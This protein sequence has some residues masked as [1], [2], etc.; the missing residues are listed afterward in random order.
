MTKIIITEEQLASLMNE[1]AS[2]KIYH[3]TSI[4]NALKIAEEDTIYLQSSL[5]SQSD[6]SYSSRKLFYLSTTR[7][8]FQAFGYSGGFSDNSVRIELDG[9]KLNE[10]LSAKPYN[11]WGETMGKWHYMKDDGF[12]LTRNKQ[13]H[14]NDE[15]EDRL[16]SSIPSIQGAHNFIKRIDVII[17]DTSDKNYSNYIQ[18]KNL[19]S[20]KFSQRIFIYDN[21]KDFNYQ[22]ENT[23]NNVLFDDMDN[24]NHAI[25]RRHRETYLDNDSINVVLAAILSGESGNIKEDSA[26]LLKKYGLTSYIYKG[27][28]KSPNK[29]LSFPYTNYQELAHSLSYTLSNLSVQPSS[30]KS[31]LLEMITDYFKRRHL[32]TMGDFIKYKE[33]NTSSSNNAQNIN[34]LIDMGIID[35]DKEI[36]ALL[37]RQT[38]TYKEIVVTDPYQVKVKDI[39]PDTENMAYFFINST[40]ENM[41]SD[42][43][44]AYE[45]Y[46]KRIFAK[47]PSLGQIM[48]MLRNLGYADKMID[49]LENILSTKITERTLNAYGLYDDMVMPQCIHDMKHNQ[50]QFLKLFKK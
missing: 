13:R 24:F 8:R 25:L 41:K 33:L 10:T 9:D 6:K 2:S 4:H 30:D 16:Y 20:T 35:G 40:E 39:N 42:T 1:S 5:A 31:K 11:Y 17:S 18:A 44:D 49:M 14:P 29:Y 45:K 38:A 47:N 7:T 43:Y 36:N 50:V 15:A 32:K 34:R 21:L 12:G 19:L 37:V 22:T 28:M 46:I 27:V 23:I 26:K 3:F 48:D